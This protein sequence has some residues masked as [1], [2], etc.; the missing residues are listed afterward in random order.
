M[1][2]LQFAAVSLILAVGW[3]VIAVSSPGG[4]LVMWAIRPTA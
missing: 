1:S 3:V 4:G 2:R